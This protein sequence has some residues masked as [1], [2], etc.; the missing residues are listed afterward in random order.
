MGFW[1][2]G[3]LVFF[4]YFINWR[5]VGRDPAGGA[6][7]PQWNPPEN[8]S[9]ALAYYVE[10]KGLGFSGWDAVSA[11][12]LNLAV[13]GYVTIDKGD[14]ELT[15][16][17]TDKQLKETLPVGEKSLYGFVSSRG[18]FVVNKTNG[19]A[20]VSMNSAFRKALEGEH[21]NVF[22]KHNRGLAI[23]G[24]II[25]VIGMVAALIFGANGVDD[26]GPLIAL[27]FPA[28]IFVIIGSNVFRSLSGGGLSGKIRSVIVGFIFLTF[29]FIQA[30]AF[31][32]ELI[33]LTVDFVD[34]SALFPV[35]GILMVNVLFFFLLGAPTPLGRKTMDKLKGLE[36]YIKLAEADRMN[37][38]GGPEMSPQHFERLL[39]YAIALNLE[40]P[41][42]EAF[43]K[44]LS[45]AAAV[46][47]GVTSYNSSFG[48]GFS[49]GNTSIGDTFGN[50][51]KDM[52]SSFVSSVP[53][54]KSS[55]SGFSG[56]GSSG[57]GG[58]GGG[59]GGW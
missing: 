40:K 14:D 30:G 45:S 58:G 19:P 25:S 38:Q 24:I 7:V 39:P 50:L 17:T 59:G 49:S 26:V 11:A 34:F 8:V 16:N 21:R 22:F 57:G 47:A 13:K 12:L 9:P 18:T 27:A 53:A 35:V 51:G 46:N 5:R 36:T 32:V 52:S 29:M 31:V 10:N 3:V 28:A 48:H 55:S 54:P 33:T 23:F 1:G 2:F 4:Y 42:S 20:V 37:L 41:W 15:I 6:I 56:G 44:W 43:E